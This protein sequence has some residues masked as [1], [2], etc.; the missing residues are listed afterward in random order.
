ML[1]AWL[2]PTALYLILAVL[3]VIVLG[4]IYRH[5]LAGFSGRLF[6]KKYKGK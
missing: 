1:E 6:P 3:T 4:V 2:G 5:S